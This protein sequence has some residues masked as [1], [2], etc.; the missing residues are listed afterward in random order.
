MMN[1][2]MVSY[3]Y[4]ESLVVRRLRSLGINLD[5]NPRIEDRF[6]KTVWNN[7]NLYA[8]DRFAEDAEILSLGFVN[9]FI[10]GFTFGQYS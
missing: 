5:D 4:I 6:I 8:Q 3:E 1:D 2:A 7:V 10:D 9:A